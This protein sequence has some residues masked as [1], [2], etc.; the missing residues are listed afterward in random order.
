MD[1]NASAKFQ[2]ISTQSIYNDLHG[3][4]RHANFELFNEAILPL[5]LADDAKERAEKSSS[6]E[7]Q[8][9]LLEQAITEYTKQYNTR[10]MMHDICENKDSVTAQTCKSD[11]D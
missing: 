10:L 6:P 4:I 3:Y 2:D 1:T 9:R 7:E 8:K 11:C 5:V